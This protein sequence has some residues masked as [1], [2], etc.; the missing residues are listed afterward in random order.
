VL[1]TRPAQQ[2]EPN[3]Q[4]INYDGERTGMTSAAESG[5]G[6]DINP[7]NRYVRQ[8]DVDGYGNVPRSSE[9]LDVGDTKLKLNMPRSKQTGGYQD[10]GGLKMG[11]SATRYK[12]AASQGR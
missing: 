2:K 12:T 6:C 10:H 7:V 9:L 8:T 11:V 4:Q 1:I 5:S 3:G